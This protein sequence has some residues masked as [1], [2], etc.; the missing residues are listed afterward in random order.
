MKET[1]LMT[2]EQLI[3]QTVNALICQFF[4]LVTS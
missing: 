2:E 1:I 4:E 3:N